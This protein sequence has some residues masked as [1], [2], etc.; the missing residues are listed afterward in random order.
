MLQPFTRKDLM[1]RSLADRIHDCPQMNNLYPNIPKDQA[2]GKY[3]SS[4]PETVPRGSRNGYVPHHLVNVIPGPQG[5]GSTTVTRLDSYPATPA[6]SFYDPQSPPSARNTP[7][8]S[9]QMM[10]S[11]SPLDELGVGVGAAVTQ[12]VQ[13]LNHA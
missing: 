2:F 1:I 12:A 10:D 4:P 13:H 7:M 11:T 9:I 5:P 8:S 3:Y 6:T